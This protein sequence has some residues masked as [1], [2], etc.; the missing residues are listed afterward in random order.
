MP[1]QL[2]CIRYASYNTFRNNIFLLI[3]VNLLQILIVRNLPKVFTKRI[4][5]EYLTRVRQVNVLF[6]GRVNTNADKIHG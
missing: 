2:I 4:C 3:H 6:L 5:L 1:C